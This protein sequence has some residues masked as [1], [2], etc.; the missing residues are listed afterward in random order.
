MDQNLKASLIANT[1]FALAY[2]I[3]QSFKIICW[4]VA[5]SHC[6]RDGREGFVFALPTFHGREQVEV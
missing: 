1:V 4:R 2:V 5:R 6:H 3:V